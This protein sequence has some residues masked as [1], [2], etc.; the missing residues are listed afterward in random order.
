MFL[1]VLLILSFSSSMIV[2][3]I[4]SVSAQSQTR[5]HTEGHFIKDSAGNVVVL[6]GAALYWRLSYPSKAKD[7]NPF[8]Y[9]DEINESSLDVFKTTGGNFIRLTV[10]GYLWS[11]AKKPTYIQAIDTFVSWCKA[12][13]IWVVMDNHNWYNPDSSSM[14]KGQTQLITELSEWR[15]FMVGL[16]QRY[17]DEPT[18]IGFDMFNEPSNGGLSNVALWRNN[19]LNVVQAIHAV[20][21]GYLCFV[22]PL[23]S[24][25]EV[26]NMQDFKDNPLPEPNIVYAAHN[27]YAWD[28]PWFDYA[29]NYGAGN[30]ALAAQQME[31]L[32]YD[33][34]IHMIDA[35]LPVI[36]M[37]TGVYKNAA[38]NPNW[39][40]WIQDSLF[41]YA[42][43]DVGVCW[44]QFDPDR[45]DSSITSL[46]ASNRTG[47]T[48]VGLIW[49]N[50]L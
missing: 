40:V 42:K 3:P 33:R 27:Y 16:A 2:I 26:N 13:G 7:Y 43:Y 11:I 17:K 34:W 24:S 44:Y 35:N 14:Y 21:S 8:A 31:Q 22:E 19:V 23:G 4:N 47:L 39:D 18:V 38:E 41:L 5:L 29:K 36:N 12:R 1:A 10:N 20:D 6:K 28:Y 37:E 46:L 48:D 49:R 30:F 25:R 9:P 45:P 15:A 32:Y 50:H